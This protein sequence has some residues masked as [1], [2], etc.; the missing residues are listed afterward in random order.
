MNRQKGIAFC[1]L[2]CALCNEGPGCFG[3]R[4][5][6]CKEKDFC[7]N[8][9]CCIEKGLLG[10]WE[11]SEF[12]CPG[13]TVNSI[14]VRAFAKFAMQYGVD[15][16]LKCLEKNEHDGVVYHCAGSLEVPSV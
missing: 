11:C 2:A 1:G 8:L 10:C 14:R 9:R 3:C 15:T 16:L 12:P 7:K 5:D 13:S 6:G 4:N